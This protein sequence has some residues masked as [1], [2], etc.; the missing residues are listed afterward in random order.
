M[1]LEYAPAGAVAANTPVDLPGGT[2]AQR[3]SRVVRFTGSDGT[4]AATSTVLSIVTA[5]PG[6]GQCRLV[7]E[8]QIEFGDAL[9]AAN[10]VTI[11]G[12]ELGSRPIAA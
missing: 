4:A 2:R 7:G 11:E 6:A 12:D 1:V 5:A 10:K 9:T 8:S 3:L